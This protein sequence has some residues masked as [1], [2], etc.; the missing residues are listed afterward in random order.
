MKYLT[1]IEICLVLLAIEVQAE[2]VQEDLSRLFNFRNFGI[3]TAGLG[4]VAL[5]HTRDDVV[6]GRLEESFIGEGP[7]DVTNI[8]G[9]S[10]FNL[11]VSI[12]MWGAG[13]VAGYGGLEK[14][15]LVLLRTLGLTQLVVAPIKFAVGRERLDG[16]NRL[17]FP[18][19]HT[20]NSFAVAR[21]L[22]RYYGLRVGVPM[23]VVGGFVAAGRIE[24]KR[25]YL[26][27]VVMG[28]VLGTLV[29][30][31]VTL[32][33]RERVRIVP[34]FTSDGAVLALSVDL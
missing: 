7:S 20:A 17:S 10:S 6:G 16:S 30:N 25:H 18:S 26:S 27:D 11:P 29:G 31:S 4:L 9:A 24:S 32:E 13:K 8:Y 1:H 3:A 15:G 21:F 19:G 34:Q 2:R 5:A 23:Y 22:H 14:T 28:A 33:N 12:G